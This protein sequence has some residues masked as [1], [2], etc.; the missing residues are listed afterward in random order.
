MTPSQVFLMS[1]L[2][3]SLSIAAALLALH[4]RKVT[5][6]AFWV[7]D[8]SAPRFHEGSRSTCLA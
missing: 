3:L 6:D 2:L 1:F 7:F 8:F 4:M 5:V